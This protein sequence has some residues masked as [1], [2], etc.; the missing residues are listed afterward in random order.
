MHNRG[1]RAC[2]FDLPRSALGLTRWRGFP[3]GSSLGNQPH[4]AAVVPPGRLSCEKPTTQGDWRVIRL[5][6]HCGKEV[7]HAAAPQLHRASDCRAL[8]HA[9][10][11]RRRNLGAALRGHTRDSAYTPY[12]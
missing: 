2:A 1:K 12:L 8:A 4:D 5:L 11:G 6:R 3:E 7:A 10:W 9:L